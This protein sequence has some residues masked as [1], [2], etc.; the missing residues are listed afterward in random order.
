[1][2]VWQF[3]VL[4]LIENQNVSSSF[5][6]E[7]QDVGFEFEEVQVQAPLAIDVVLFRTDRDVFADAKISAQ[8][9]L[10]CRRCLEFFDYLLEASFSVQY[11]LTHDPL[12]VSDPFRDIGIRYYIGD[13]IDTAEDIRESLVLEL[14]L[15]PLCSEGCR[16]LC[17]TCGTNLNQG[18]CGCV[19]ST[20]H[21]GKF[22]VLADL[23]KD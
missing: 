2:E 12:M 19:S 18:Q 14:P 3:K 4:D 1:M 5:L 11:Q 20:A 10:Q 16:G 8:T 13:Y 7:A 6:V 22:A 15:W 21:P 23:L 9:R 17:P